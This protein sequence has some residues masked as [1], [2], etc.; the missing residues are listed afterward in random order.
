M[1]D[2]IKLMLLPIKS[3]FNRL[4]VKSTDSY[5]FS[6]L[7]IS[8]WIVIAVVLY[9]IEKILP[10]SENSIYSY[11]PDLF[12]FYAI[13]LII[14][15]AI[16]Y[17]FGKKKRFPVLSFSLF[18]GSALTVF[19]YYV[20]IGGNE[21]KWDIVKRLSYM[22]VVIALISSIVVIWGGYLALK[23]I[24]ES[25]YTNKIAAQTNKLS[26]FKM[27]IDLLQE[28]KAR[29]ERKVVFTLFDDNSKTHKEYERWTKEE[30]EAVHYTLTCLDQIG[31]MVKYDLLDYNFL[32]GWFYSIYKCIFI[33]KPYI[34]EK[35][36]QYG[37][38]VIKNDNVEESSN[39]FLG[40]EELI[41]RKCKNTVYDFETKSG[42]DY[43]F[44]P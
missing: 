3:Y 10:F 20:Y 25:V 1:I 7:Y 36:R 39:Y 27:M 33:S 26:S 9:L 31:L 37:C 29:E 38:R 16:V 24:K 17:W 19:M 32:E 14:N 40:I 15:S 41:T 18:A 35:Y 43:N 23:Q 22:E 12:L 30:K 8:I 6:I 28:N 42:E 34:K 5:S 11:F 4:K 21:E 13:I 44:K 2:F